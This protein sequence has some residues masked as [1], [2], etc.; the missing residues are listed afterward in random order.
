[1]R[2]E[3]SHQSFSDSAIPIVS[4][5]AYWSSLFDGIIGKSVKNIFQ[6]LLSSVP[7]PFK[8][9]VSKRK[10]NFPHFD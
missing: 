2:G 10:L 3:N 4:N 5:T 1:M 8:Y 7:K 6:K 9:G